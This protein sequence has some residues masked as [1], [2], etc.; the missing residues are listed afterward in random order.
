MLRNITQALKRSGLKMKMW[1]V[2][3]SK[4]VAFSVP[5]LSRASVTPNFKYG[6]LLQCVQLIKASPMTIASKT[7]EFFYMPAQLGRTIYSDLL[8]HH[9][10][11]TE[12]C[13]FCAAFARWHNARRVTAGS[14]W[15]LW[16]SVVLVFCSV[17][18]MILLD[19]RQILSWRKDEMV[20][21]VSPCPIMIISRA[22][23]CCSRTAISVST[24]WTSCWTHSCPRSRSTKAVGCG[25][26]PKSIPSSPFLY[27]RQVTLW[28]GEGLQDV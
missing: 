13:P 27:C 10:R 15:L 1:N 26:P 7:A 20:L 25:S 16:R 23:G 24:S 22:D 11:H 14:Q 17:W 6:K 2:C 8:E 28:T 5:V 12:C 18:C 21:I 9:D 19:G 4:C 3:R